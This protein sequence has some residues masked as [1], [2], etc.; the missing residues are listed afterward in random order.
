MYRNT[1]HHTPDISLHDR[2]NK[3]LRNTHENIEI[4]SNK[5]L[6]LQISPQSSVF[7]DKMP[8]H[9]APRADDKERCCMQQTAGGC[10]MYMVH[11]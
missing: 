7:C 3:Q 10:I 6:S 4:Q 2:T 9:Q 8:R 11:I 1:V 5:E